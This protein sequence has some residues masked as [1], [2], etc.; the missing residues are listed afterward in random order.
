MHDCEGQAFG[1]MAKIFPGELL[2][3]AVYECMQI[4]GVNSLNKEYPLE[5]FM[6]EALVFPIYDGGNMGMQRRKI[7]GVIA[8]PDFDPRAFSECRPV[9]YKKSMTGYGVLPARKA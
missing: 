2:M 9:P 1:A 3:G 6:R 4:V 8:D 5:K 7:W